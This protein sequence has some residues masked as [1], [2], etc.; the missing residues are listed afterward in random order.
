M[1]K[2]GQRYKS[3]SEVAKFCEITE[4]RVQQLRKDG[5]LT[6]IKTSDGYRY[7]FVVAVKQYIKYL[8][9]CV[10]RKGNPNSDKEARRIDADIMQKQ[11]KAKLLSFEIGEVRGELHRSEDVQ[12]LL[13][14]LAASIR[15]MLSA[16]P[17][18]LSPIVAKMTNPKLIGAEIKKEIN[19]VLTQLSKFEYNP[20]YF[21]D[22]RKSRKQT[23]VTE[24]DEI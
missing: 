24:D 17:S 9:G 11:N 6:A 19:L 20:E 3:A 22:K 13:E 12:M 2:L 4:R 16:L 23:I 21:R 14:D 10:E 18:R 7:D 1:E 8:Q 15:S 5:T